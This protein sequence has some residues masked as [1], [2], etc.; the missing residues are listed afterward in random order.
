MKPSKHGTGD[1]QVNNKI[2]HGKSYDRIYRVWR[3]MLDRCE[4]KTDNR[5]SLYGE[6]GI[7]VCQ[8]WHNAKTFIDWAYA[9]G[10]TDSLQIDRINTDGNYE[11]DNCRFV[12][13]KENNRNK[14]N[15]RRLTIDGMT[16]NVTEW[17]EKTGVKRKTIYERLRRGWAEKDAVYRRAEHDR[18]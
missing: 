13:C 16:L 3:N 17:A 8:E 4:S 6:R 18:I 14:R 1:A 12:T 9:N 2:I 5:Y 7:T 11:P 10:Y 15:N